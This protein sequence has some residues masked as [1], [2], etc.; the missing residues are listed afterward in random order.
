[1]PLPA[2]WKTVTV[3]ATFTRADTAGPA[4]G[5]VQFT[6]VKAV[7]IA[8]DVVLPALITAT[9][10]GSGQI[11]VGLPCPNSAGVTSLVYE[12]IERVPGGRSYYIEVLASM[13]GSIALA[14]FDPLTDDQAAYYSLRGPTGDVTPSA[15]AAQAAAEAASA[16]ADASADAAA[17]SANAAAASIAAG[18]I[19][20]TTSAGLAATTN[21]QYFSVPS[22]DSSE[23]LILYKNNAGSALEVKRYPSADRVTGLEAQT[24]PVVDAFDVTVSRNL[25]NKANAVNGQLISYSNGLNVAYANGMSFGYFPVEA[26]KTYTVSMG[27]ALGFH[28]QHALFCRDASGA[29]LGIDHTIGATTGMANPP[30]GITWTGNS[31]VTFT[32]PVGSLIR[33]V[34]LMAEYSVHTT[35]DFNRVIGT[36]QAEEGT[37]ATEYQRYAP[38]G[39]ATLKTA[40]STAQVAL[41]P[42]RV[43]KAGNDIYIRTPFDATQDLV[44]KVA[45]V[46]GN[47][48]TVNVQGAR[49]IAK[50]NTTSPS[51]AW[52]FGTIIHSAVDDSAPLNYNGTFIGANHGASFVREV[53]SSGHGKAVQDV[54]STWTD[55]AAAVWTLMKI[56]DA[57]KLW[58]MPSNTAAYPAW[59]F[60]STLT[61][62]LT[63]SSGA[64]NTGAITVGSSVLTQLWP[65][66]QNQTAKVFLDGV[67]EVTADGTYACGFV[68]VVNTYDIANPAAVVTYV[69]GLVGGATQPSFIDPSIAADVHRTLTYRYSENGSCTITDGMR[70]LT[71]GLSWS[72]GNFP[73]TQ[74]GPLTY[75]GKELWQYVPRVTP[76]VGSLKTWNFAA[77]ERIDGAMEQVN[78][79]SANWSDANNPPDR[80]AQI[81]R[82]AGVAEFGMMIGVSP[83]RGTGPAATRKFL[84]TDALFVSAIR[85]Q[86][87]KAVGTPAPI[88]AG[89][90]YETVAYRAYWTAGMCPQATAFTW[91]RDGKDI[92]VIADFHQNV[93]F[94]ALKMPSQF[95]GMDV[96][97]VDKT[98]SATVHGNG[99]V[100]ADGVLVSVNDGYG[101]VVLK[102][103]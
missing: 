33:F 18:S 78:L 58:F 80:M 9:L 79:T 67:T 70:V 15:L 102:L 4:A 65:C 31:K 41:A 6:P 1:M 93:D 19:Y 44:L 8:A 28:S 39:L 38:A 30:T 81:V 92:V 47:N 59:S 23:Y 88:T 11:S 103:T 99:V 45:L 46:N 97:V 98:A 21:G 50:S 83:V 68:D 34:G 37:T 43:T 20:A 35:D 51:L 22:A 25:Y 57:N 100:T 10:N 84:L 3:T 48:S 53:T 77:Q 7:G 16:A 17:A 55:S 71:S 94:A 72:G 27:D 66:L 74:A 52:V 49:T 14:D 32:I 69:R 82:T 62:N 76:K 91:Y 42:V 24:A 87:L 61:G 63:H 89:S 90:Y 95:T 86:Y 75:T 54:G 85:K 2:S 101:Y 73:A 60:N 40:A 5:S 26:G 64:T 29:F 96:T 12:V 36:V 13:T 56:V